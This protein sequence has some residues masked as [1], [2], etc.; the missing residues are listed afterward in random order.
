MELRAP[1][2]DMIRG[3]AF[4]TELHNGTLAGLRTQVYLLTISSAP[5]S[6]PCQ[7]SDEHQ[8][9]LPG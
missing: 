9:L 2:P 8:R 6:N 1:E 3:M 5:R 7:L 4:G